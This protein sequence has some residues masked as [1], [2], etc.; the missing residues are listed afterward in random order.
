M[1][2]AQV[3]E[4]RR[5][6]QVRG[7]R[8]FTVDPVD[9][10]AQPVVIFHEVAQPLPADL[11][12]LRVIAVG[13]N[14]GGARH[15]APNA[16][17]S[18]PKNSP[19]GHLL[20]AVLVQH[21]RNVLEKN[22]DLVGVLPRAQPGVLAKLFA[23]E[24]FRRTRAVPHLGERAE[25]A[26]FARRLAAEQR[27]FEVRFQDDARCTR[28]DQKRRRAVVALA[29]DDFAL[30]R[31]NLRNARVVAKDFAE[32]RALG[33]FF[34]VHPVE[35]RGE[36][37]PVHV[38]V[39]HVRVECGVPALRS[40]EDG[41]GGGH[42]FGKVAGG[43]LACALNVS[44]AF[45]LTLTL[46]RWEREQPLAAFLIENCETEIACGFAGRWKQFSLSAPSE[47]REEVSYSFSDKLLF[48]V[49]IENYARD[50]SLLRTAD[51]PVKRATGIRCFRRVRRAFS[52]NSPPPDLIAATTHR[53]ATA[54]ATAGINLH[55]LRLREFQNV[56]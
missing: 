22:V 16:A 9:V 23:R 12:Q 51:A 40:F 55:A 27:W 11:Q 41:W 53:T 18:A 35:R 28:Q 26:F 39:R 43:K 56:F 19:G 3:F 4:Q 31:R 6:A 54:R 42:Q 36:Q 2:L 29:H 15:A 48:P 32:R 24:K 52:D 5:G 34:R 25:D 37:Q 14:R 45:S 38:L 33:K 10:L 20:G 17:I 44:A 50:K 46:S 49:I 7:Q 30:S 13:K 47:G 21:A 8:A 1:F